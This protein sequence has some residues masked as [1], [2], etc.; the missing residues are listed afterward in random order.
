MLQV[1]HAC[2][3]VKKFGNEIDRQYEI[4]NY[5]YVLSTSDEW[6]PVYAKAF[7][8]DEHQNA[9]VRNTTNGLLG[10]SFQRRADWHIE[11]SYWKSTLNCR[12]SM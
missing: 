2:G 8:V 3:A 7:G 12:V 5:D 9:A 10:R 4:K 6:K 11:M 1:W